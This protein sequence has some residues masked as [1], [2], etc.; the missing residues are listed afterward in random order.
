MLLSLCVSREVALAAVSHLPGHSARV[1]VVGPFVDGDTTLTG[2]LRVVVVGSFV[3][4]DTTLTGAQLVVVVVGPF[5][6][7]GTTLT[8]ALLLLLFGQDRPRAASPRGNSCVFCVVRSALL[9][10]SLFRS[11]I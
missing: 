8:G 2:A 4:G 9:L 6:D 5:V 7:G 11:A 1:V 10:I 3:D